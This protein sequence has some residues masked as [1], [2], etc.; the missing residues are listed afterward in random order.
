MSLA[1]GNYISNGIKFAKGDKN[2]KITLSGEK[3]PYSIEV[4]NDGDGISSELKGHLWSVMTKEDKARTSGSGSG[5]GLAICKK[6]FDFHGCTYGLRNTENGVV[7]W[8]VV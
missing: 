7:F 2:V 1:V 5:M 4:Y 3:S 6:I 8:V